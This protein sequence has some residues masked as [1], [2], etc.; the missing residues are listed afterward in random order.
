MDSDGKNRKVSFRSDAGS[1]FTAPSSADLNTS[2]TYSRDSV[3]SGNGSVTISAPQL[4]MNMM[5][6]IHNRDPYEVYEFAKLL[7]NGSMVGKKIIGNLTC[8]ILCL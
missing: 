4:G 1:E 2:S 3:R 8:Q 6:T 5:R 7:G